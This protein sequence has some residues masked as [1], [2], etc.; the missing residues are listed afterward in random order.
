M[1]SEQG[2]KKAHEGRWEA[3]REEERIVNYVKTPFYFY[4]FY[5]THF[6]HAQPTALTC[7]PEG[8]STKSLSSSTLLLILSRRRRSCKDLFT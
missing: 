3:E 1:G 2:K 7:T 5:S 4:Y 8:P 6:K